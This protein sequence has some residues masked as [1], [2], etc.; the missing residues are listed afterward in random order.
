MYIEDS[1]TDYCKGDRLSGIFRNWGYVGNVP[2]YS[3]T[4]T[5]KLSRWLVI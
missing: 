1:L 5:T 3:L 4:I 2:M